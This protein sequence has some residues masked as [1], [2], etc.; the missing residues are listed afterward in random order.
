MCEGCFLGTCGVRA[1]GLMCIV[2]DIARITMNGDD[3]VQPVVAA[4]SNQRWR[5][6]IVVSGSGNR[7]AGR[8]ATRG[9]GVEVFKSTKSTSDIDIK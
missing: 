6:R 5:K 9:T 8:R 4:R 2:R 1:K 7:G 3:H